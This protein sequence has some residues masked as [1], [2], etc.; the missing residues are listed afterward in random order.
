MKQFLLLYHGPATPPGASHKG[1]PDWFNK[2]GDAL[3][4]IGSPMENGFVVQSDGSTSDNSSSLN[5]FSIIQ[6]EDRA[7]A[8]DLVKDHP[9]LAAGS[10]YMIEVF[11][12]PK[13]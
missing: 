13:G 7:Q 8:L 2:I 4:D 12:V 1:W 10:E 3:V 9:F 6:A 11:D 5:G